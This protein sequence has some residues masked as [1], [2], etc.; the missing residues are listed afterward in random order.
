MTRITYRRGYGLSHS[1]GYRW[2]NETDCPVCQSLAFE[3]YE[4]MVD[5]GVNGVRAIKYHYW[6]MVVRRLHSAD[7]LRWYR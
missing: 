6:L 7:G 1:T 4:R 5:G 2:H 3:A